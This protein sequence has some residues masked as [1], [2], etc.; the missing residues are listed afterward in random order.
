MNDTK[1]WQV[2]IN[3][4]AAV[5][6]GAEDI[7]QCVYAII[8]TVKGSDPLRADF[9]S[10]VYRYIDRPESEARPLIA[11]AVSE[12]LRRW[13]QRIVVKKCRITSAA[14]GSLG[15]VIEAEAATDET[16]VTI[17]VNI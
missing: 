7:A 1:N 4:P 5:V 16:P 8:T 13:E 10:D 17:T 3:D 12:A 6:E 2:S 15:I 9:G 14:P 11:Y